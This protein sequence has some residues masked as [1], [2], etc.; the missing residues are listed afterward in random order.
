MHVE[1]RNTPASGTANYGFSFFD[2]II[3]DLVDCHEGQ[4]HIILQF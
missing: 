3:A 1:G 4:I 2:K